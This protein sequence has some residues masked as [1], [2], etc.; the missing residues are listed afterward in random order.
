MRNESHEQIYKKGR[1]IWKKK[2]S[3]KGI[4]RFNFQLYPLKFLK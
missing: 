2:W 4:Q 3:E 1:V